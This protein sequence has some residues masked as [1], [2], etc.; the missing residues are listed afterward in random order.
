MNPVIPD[1]VP[2]PLPAPPWLPQLLMVFTFILHLVAMNWLVGGSAILAL[3]SFR[4]R[5]D[6]RHRELARRGSR[7][8]PPVVAF[9]ITLGVAP[10]LF[11]QLVYGQLFFTSSI[12]MAWAWLSVVLL[13][14]LGYYGVYGFSLQQEELGWR[15]AWVMLGTTLLFAVI[16][17][18]Y[19]QNLS[20]MQ[21]PGDFYPTF[22]RH[23]AGN[24]LGR[25]DGVT[26]ARYFHF[27]VA[28][29]AIA[30][31]GV[32]LASHLWKDQSPEFAAW[33]RRYGVVWFTAGTGVQFLVGF[34]FLLSLP[35]E[36]R[37]M[38]F[39]ADALATALLVVAVALA[40][41]ALL[42]ALKSL[43]AASF[44]I[45]GTIAL[46]SIIR[47]LVRTAYLQPHF[48]PRALAVEGQ[49]VVFGIFAVLLLVGIA[50]VAWM[51]YHFFRPATGGT[52]TT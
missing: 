48:D 51:L 52:Q 31:L 18:I 25:I 28:A 45:F 23:G 35:A 42:A 29:L 11:L 16:M 15:G 46:M 30:G 47:H 3:S 21:R 20:L 43:A 9:T 32:A 39:G 49:W 37:R 41:L 34:W 26:L 17:M 2:V 13:L 6:A 50:T 33:A 38:F 36:I 1:S 8:M 7:L 27:L 44:A 5:R 24:Y 12:W 40:V 10:L 4:G 22:L 14:M 19:V